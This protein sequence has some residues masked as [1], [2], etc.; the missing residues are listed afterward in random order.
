[1]PLAALR[2]HA[3]EI[4]FVLKLL[5]MLPSGAI[6]RLTRRP[7]IERV[8]YPSRA[9]D[10]E[11]D[12][13]RPPGRGPHPGIVLCLGVV[14]FGVE[15]PQVARLSDALARAGFVALIHWSDTMRDLRLAAEDAADIAHAYA[16][17]IE[18]ED[19]DPRRSGLF[20]TCV[21]GTFALLAAAHPLVR[22]RV[23]FVGAFAPFSSMWTLAV[24]VASGTRDDGAGAVAWDVDPLTRDVFR[25]TLESLR[26]AGGPPALPEG[27][28]RQTVEAALRE[29][30]ARTREELDAMSP[31]LHVADIH[32]PCIVFGHD[33]D[34]AVIPV[35][36]S[37]R[38]ATALAGRPGVLFTEYGMFQH[39]DP[40]KRRL[41]APAF[42]REVLR[43]YLS[44][45][46]MFRATT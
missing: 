36:E 23:M 40:T 45:Y 3:R 34:D 11:A 12:L 16:W 17:L 21:G 5:P 30:P 10:I 28:D 8:H 13:Y 29:I 22:D 32:A 27:A 4:A 15:H 38:L 31:I 6:D 41:S 26:V 33:R 14:P 35:G 1:M 44:L 2:A 43:F 18:R 7:I 24:D 25:R 42:T 46:P 39:A 37:R 19:V 20:G 9:G